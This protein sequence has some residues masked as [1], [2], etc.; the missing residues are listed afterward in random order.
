MKALPVLS[1]EET[2]KKCEAALLRHHQACKTLLTGDHERS[3]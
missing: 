3:E 2:N 1:V